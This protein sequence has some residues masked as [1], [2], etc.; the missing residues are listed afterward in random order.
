MSGVRHTSHRATSGT[1]AARASNVS[2]SATVTKFFVE[3]KG[4]P[5]AR[6]EVAGYGATPGERKTFTIKH[7]AEAKGNN[8]QTERD[9]QVRRGAAAR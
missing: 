9:G 1:T 6:V 3:E 8:R 5:D 7:Y 4:R 2:S